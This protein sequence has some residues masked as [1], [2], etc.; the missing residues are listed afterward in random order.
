MVS[1]PSSPATVLG[2]T[3]S[4]RRVA[5]RFSRRDLTHEVPDNVCSEVETSCVIMRGFVAKFPR[6]YGNCRRNELMA[7]GAVMEAESSGIRLCGIGRAADARRSTDITTCMWLG[8]RALR[9]RRLLRT[10]DVS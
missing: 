4:W 3:T 2:N 9:V 6:P 10:G 5:V 8:R 7:P 1:W